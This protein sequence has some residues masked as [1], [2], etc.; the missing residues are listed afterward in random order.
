M[1]K[2][3]EETESPQPG[4]GREETGDALARAW[5]EAAA[6][7]AV[8]GGVFCL[9]VTGVLVLGHV[10]GRLSD[11]RDS[12][13]LDSFRAVLLRRP[14][15]EDLKETIRDLDLRLREEYFCRRAF[16]ERGTYLLLG[17]GLLLLGA[18]YLTWRTTTGDDRS[19]PLETSNGG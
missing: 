13:E 8:I 4:A 16:A 9:V 1:A 10:R 6:G 19:P 18:L 17:F 3:E 14:K 12:A 2:P 7:A 5:F 15:D 11:P